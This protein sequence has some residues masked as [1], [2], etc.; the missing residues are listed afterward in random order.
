MRKKMLC[1]NQRVQFVC[2]NFFFF[3]IMSEPEK[4]FHV[5]ILHGVASGWV[6]DM[7][8]TCR[9]WIVH[10]EQHARQ[11]EVWSDGVIKLSFS[12]EDL[13]SWRAFQTERQMDREKP[14]FVLLRSSSEMV[15]KSVFLPFQEPLLS[16]VITF[17]ELCTQ[18]L[19]WTAD[20]CKT[21]SPSI[22]R[23]VTQEIFDMTC[24][25]VTSHCRTPLAL[26]QLLY[27]IK[28]FRDGVSISAKPKTKQ[29]TPASAL[30]VDRKLYCLGDRHWKLLDSTFRE[31]LLQNE[32]F[33]E[34]RNAGRRG[35]ITISL[36]S[37]KKGTRKRKRSD[38][39][40]PPIY[41]QDDPDDIR[42][43][44]TESKRVM[45][46]AKDI[47]RDTMTPG[48]TMYGQLKLSVGKPSPPRPG[49]AYRFQSE[50]WN[51]LSDSQ[52]T[53]ILERLAPLLKLKSK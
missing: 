16:S 23:Q 32:V 47:L 17:R 9:L 41:Q 35:S 33:Q 15:L 28:Q 5:S 20:F 24:Q 8:H 3:T 2:Q 6:T 25:F 11:V 21:L 26:T 4:Q 14:L 36:V 40:L 44:F 1:S 39:T 19:R 42:V 45:D 51:K 46:I 48:V 12:L 30:S 34:Q 38:T 53:Q 50:S 22:Q 29:E 49:T 13:S 43:W 31:A 27:E 18:S 7:L 10:I 37:E 52:R